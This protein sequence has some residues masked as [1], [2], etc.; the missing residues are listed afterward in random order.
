M[1]FL[2]TLPTP[3]NDL[4]LSLIVDVC[5]VL[6]PDANSFLSSRKQGLPCWR[7]LS[8]FFLQFWMVLSRSRSRV[9]SERVMNQIMSD[10][11]DPLVVHVLHLTHDFTLLFLPPSSLVSSV[12]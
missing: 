11:P 10:V 9:R 1:A 12:W 2:R 3:T 5:L 7:S 6:A 4:L 8:F